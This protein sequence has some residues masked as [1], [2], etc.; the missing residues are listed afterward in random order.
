MSRIGHSL[1][2]EL[3][4][5]GMADTIYIPLASEPGVSFLQKRICS[6]RGSKFF[7]VRVP[8]QIHESEK[9]YPWQH[10]TPFRSRFYPC[11]RIGICVLKSR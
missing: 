8:S 3:E 11:P 1:K 7:P 10:S 6:L 2:P 4:W 5:N 9:D